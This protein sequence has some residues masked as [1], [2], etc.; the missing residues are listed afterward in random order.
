MVE[1]LKAGLYDT[2][3]DVGRF[4]CQEFGVPMS[5]VMDQ[6]SA[7]L[8]NSILGNPINDAVMESVVVGPYLKFN[9][10]TALCISGADMNARLNDLEIKTN[11]A[12]PVKSG[13]ILKLG[14][15]NYGCRSYVAVLG[16]FQTE[17]EMGSRS[18][19]EGITASHKL[20]K[21]AMLPIL[22]RSNCVLDS[23]ASVK[24]DVHHFETQELEV[25]KG[26]EFEKL[27]EIQ[28]QKV[29]SLKYSISKDSNRMA[30]LLNETIDNSL[31][32]IIT[33]LVLPGTV[34]L[35]PSGQLIILMRDC[36]TTGGYPRILQLT[37]NSI[38]RLSQ[39]FTSNN[40][41]FKCI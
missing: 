27:D 25:Y 24:I 17:F 31:K 40:I 19:Y 1:V 10:Q 36:Q 3:Q 9:Q 41:S 11:I 37:K 14:S 28:Q 2:I 7:A 32:G 26:A 16:G 30:Y 22:K 5:G 34:Q 13:D 23:Y 12:Y 35:T 4:G 8:A 38:N 6:Y 15:C 18:M 39:K 20:N 21:G 29:M 33:S